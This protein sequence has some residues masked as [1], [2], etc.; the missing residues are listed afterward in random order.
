MLKDVAGAYYEQ[1]YNCAESILH[2]GNDY[3]DLGLCEHDMRMVAA[4][5]GVFQIG[6]VCGALSVAARVIS[7]K[8][9][10]TKAHDQKTEIAKVTQKLV[11]AFQKRMGAR[12][13]AKI[14]PVFYSKDVKCYNTVTTAA[15][16]LEQVIQEWEEEGKDNA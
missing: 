5:G 6:D 13:C 12:T 1:G 10:E 7:S 11:L 14:K 4:F 16:V 9:I 3:Y 2:A 8:Y 15:E